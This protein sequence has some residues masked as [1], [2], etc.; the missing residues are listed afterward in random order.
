MPL[1][2]DAYIFV[3]VDRLRKVFDDSSDAA[4]TFRDDP[5]GSSELCRLDITPKMHNSL[6][7]G[8][9]HVEPFQTS[10]FPQTC[11]DAALNGRLK[12]DNSR[13]ALRFAAT[14]GASPSS[15]LGTHAE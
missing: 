14:K 10:I 5:C 8:H 12:Q 9:F 6:G 15:T 1:V 2:L 13:L 7:Y 11:R 3:V 4:N